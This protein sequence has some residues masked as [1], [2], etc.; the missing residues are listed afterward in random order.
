M[1]FRSVSFLKKG[2]S[3]FFVLNVC[4]IIGL[5]TLVNDFFFACG[6]KDAFFLFLYSHL[7]HK[8][9]LQQMTN[10][11]IFFS[12]FLKKKV[13]YSMRI[14]CWPFLLFLKKR[15]ILKLSSAA[16]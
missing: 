11:A 12:N 13:K 15:K 1:G 4:G 6:N 3:Y 5:R 16:N 10:F 14:V 8:S 2:F 7:K 9:Q